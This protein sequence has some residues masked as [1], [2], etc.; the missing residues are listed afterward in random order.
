[1]KALSVQHNG[2]YAETHN[3]I[4]LA[5]FCE[6]YDSYFSDTETKRILE[7]FDLFD[8]VGRY[9]G[10]AKFDPLSKGKTVGGK[11]M[12]VAPGVQ[13]AGASFWSD[14]Y[15]RDLDSFVFKVRSFLDFEK[16]KFDDGLKSILDRNRKSALMG[17]WKGKTP[18]RV[19]LTKNN[20]YFRA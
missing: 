17:T 8:Q 6:P 19:V 7:Q 13:I 14:S 15:L 10:A 16:I 2:T 20:S 9:G 3:L 5:T 18:L 12:T 1:M 11:S 4:E